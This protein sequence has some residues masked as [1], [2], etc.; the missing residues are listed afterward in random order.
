VGHSELGRDWDLL[1]VETN[2]PRPALTALRGL[3]R[4]G[5]CRNPCPDDKPEAALSGDT[6]GLTNG[7]KCPRG[8]EDVDEA[9]HRLAKQLHPGLLITLEAG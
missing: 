2:Q 8:P 7:T 3:S 6:T 4:I 9:E 1:P 5:V